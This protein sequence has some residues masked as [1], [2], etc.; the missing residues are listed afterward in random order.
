MRVAT[1]VRFKLIAKVRARLLGVLLTLGLFGCESTPTVPQLNPL[2]GARLT[3]TFGVRSNDPVTGKALVDGHHDGYDLAAA[4][5]SPIRAT[6]T[7]RVSFAGSQGGYGKLIVLEHPEGWSTYYGHA[8]QL[9]VKE[10]QTVQAG[11]VVAYVGSTG[12]STGPHLH[13]ELRHHG[14]AVDPQLAIQSVASKAKGTQKVAKAKQKQKAQVKTRLARG[15]MTLSAPKLSVR[16]SRRKRPVDHGRDA[17]ARSAT[18]ARSW[19]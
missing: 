5:G 14:V 1:A 2:T 8:S 9:A 6:K 19:G 11:Q 12:H 7:G 10:G 4:L 13:Y 3:S 18:L 15:K 16:P 17:R